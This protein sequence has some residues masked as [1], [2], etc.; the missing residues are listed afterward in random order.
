MAEGEIVDKAAAKALNH[1]LITIHGIR[2]QFDLWLKKMG[3]IEGVLKRDQDAIEEI[4]GEIDEIVDFGL[5]L[6]DP[7]NESIQS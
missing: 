2:Q 7:C 4:M 6:Q 5:Q 3:G 1:G